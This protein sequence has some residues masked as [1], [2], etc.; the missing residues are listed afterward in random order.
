MLEEITQSDQLVFVHFDLR[1]Q[2]VKPRI[3]DIL[4]RL[5][6]ILIFLNQLSLELLDLLLQRHDQECLS[7]IALRSLN[8]RCKGPR[9]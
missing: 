6:Q 3:L 5:S 2:L 4:P 1:V 9:V 7:L 8:D